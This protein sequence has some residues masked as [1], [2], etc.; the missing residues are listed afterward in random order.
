MHHIPISCRVAPCL[1]V[2]LFLFLIPNS[3]A[4]AGD[5][6]IALYTGR[7][8]NTTFLETVGLQTDTW[9]STIYAVAFGKKFK[10][11]LNNR[12]RFEAEL[13]AAHHDGLENF[14]DTS[15]SSGDPGWGWAEG[16]SHET[17]NSGHHTHQEFNAV[18]VARWLAFPWDD[19][20][21]TSIAFGE[22]IS[23]ATKNPRVEIDQP[24]QNHGYDYPISKWLN[25]LLVEYT[26]SLP[27]VF[28]DWSVFCRIHHRSGVYG[29][30]N[31]YS[32]GSD[33]LTFG[34]RY[35]Y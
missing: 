19:I 9:D 10:P 20:V 26:F 5:H 23:Y 4:E 21:D 22:G 7:Y 28:P 30:F 29:L 35:D 3:Y 14:E 25:Y 8:S 34:L 13:Q 2:F 1:S 15:P 32:G 17:L 18:I 12:F 31:N 24:A 16:Y 11:R 33:F 27:K 6:Y